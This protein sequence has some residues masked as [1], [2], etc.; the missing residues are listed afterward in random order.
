MSKRLK[1]IQTVLR[2]IPEHCAVNS[3]GQK[4]VRVRTTH[5]LVWASELRV[6]LFYFSLSFVPFRRKK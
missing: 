2:H 3:F 1:S 6:I 4:E 5:L